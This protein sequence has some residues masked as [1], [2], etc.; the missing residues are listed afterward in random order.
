MKTFAIEDDANPDLPKTSKNVDVRSVLKV[1]LVNY[2][3]S[4]FAIKYG[5]LEM[6]M[7][8]DMRIFWLVL[9]DFLKVT[10]L[11]W[12]SNQSIVCFLFFLN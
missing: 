11:G 9:D 10:P 7:E 6:E 1:K 3:K 5:F 12:G 8:N 4:F 2:S